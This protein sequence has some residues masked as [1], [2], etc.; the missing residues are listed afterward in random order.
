MGY[1]FFVPDTTFESKEKYYQI[2][3]NISAENIA[4]DLEEQGIIRFHCYLDFF[5]GFMAIGHWFNPENTLQPKDKPS[6]KQP[7]N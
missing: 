5:M 1:L 6:S 3:K 7:D 2:G 4:A